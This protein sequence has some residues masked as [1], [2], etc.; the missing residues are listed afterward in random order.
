MVLGIWQHCMSSFPVDASAKAAASASGRQ[1]VPAVCTV[2]G[3]RGRGGREPRVGGGHQALPGA[4]ATAAEAEVS[5]EAA[6]A[7]GLVPEVVLQ[8]E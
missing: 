4:G 6:G 7:V 8:A 3:G 2:P 5:A 1:A